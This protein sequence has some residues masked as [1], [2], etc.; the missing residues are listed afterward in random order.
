MSWRNDIKNRINQIRENEITIYKEFPNKD[1]YKKNKYKIFVITCLFVDIV[2]YSKMCEEKDYEE[3]ARIIKTF[4]EGVLDIMNKYEL[5]HIQI[6]GDGIFG[7]LP[8]FYKNDK[9]I[10]KIFNCALDING[11]L[12]FFWKE[13]DYRISLAENEELMII[14]GENNTREVVF[15]G[16]A[17]NEAKNQMKDNKKNCILINNNFISN[18]EIVIWNKD[19]N[20]SYIIGT[21]NK[22]TKYSNWAINWK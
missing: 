13:M 11:Y 21:T 19:K 15:A 8:T 7:V 2:G 22:G 6:Q 20:Q 10:E 9:N 14:V 12:S 17:V 5:K 4:Q 1:N 16:G 18:N 3:I